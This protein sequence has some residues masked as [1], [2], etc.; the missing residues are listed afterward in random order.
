MKSLIAPIVLASILISNLALNTGCSESANS[1]AIVSI[2]TVQMNCTAANCSGFNGNPTMIAFI[3][4]SGCTSPGFGTVVSTSLNSVSCVFGVGCSGVL[5]GWIDGAGTPTS[6][7]P[8]G[9]YSVCVIVDYN[10]NYNGLG[11]AMSG[12]SY[13]TLDNVAVSNGTGTQTVTSFADVP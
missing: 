1:G 10:G 11:A 5:S 6:K 3:T 12:D 9:N 4:S 13:G 8:E 7:M 2:P